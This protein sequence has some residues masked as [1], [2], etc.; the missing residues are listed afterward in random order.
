MSEALYAAVVIGPVNMD[1]IATL[2]DG[3]E[4]WEGDAGKVFIKIPGNPIIVTGQ[5][6]RRD[7]EIT[8]VISSIRACYLVKP[9]V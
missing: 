6:F 9:I 8:D 1:L 3:N 4:V 7:Y 5:Q 2:N